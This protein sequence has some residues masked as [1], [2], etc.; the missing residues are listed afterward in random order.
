M[1]SAETIPRNKH[2]QKLGRKGLLTRKRIMKNAVNLLRVRPYSDLTVADVTYEADVS[3]SSFYVYFDDIEDLMF[4]CVEEATQDIS[5]VLDVLDEE[6][7]VANLRTQIDRFVKAYER[8]WE[9]H[10]LELRIRNLEADKGNARFLQLRYDSSFEIV[11]GLEAKVIEAHPKIKNALALAS[12]VFAALERVVAAEVAPVRNP[13]ANKLTR[14]KISSSV[15]D[16]IY[17]LLYRGAL[18]FTQQ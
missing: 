2:G 10:R 11:S 17:L 4:A 13:R 1:V 15:S 18:E 6:W 12:V 14:R 9:M 3:S 5:G 16:L 7:T 8:L